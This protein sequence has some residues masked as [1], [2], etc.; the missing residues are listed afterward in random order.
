MYSITT[1]TPPVSEPV[2]VATLKAS[3][4]LNTS[5]EDS[6]LAGY[7]TTARMQFEH[8][9]QRA[10]FTQTLRQYVQAIAHTG[11]AWDVCDPFGI[12]NLYPRQS[13]YPTL[14]I[15]RGDVQSVSSVHYYDAAGS[16]QTSSTHT[17]DLI[18]N[19]A[20]VY[21]ASG[22]PSIT[23]AQPHVAYCD[24]V[25]GWTSVPADVCTAIQLMASHYYEQRSA[26]VTDNLKE[27]PHGF[28]SICSKYTLGLS[29]SWGQ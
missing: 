11:A 18:G 21:W 27:L 19:P 3:L 24:F 9:T 25:A 28:A 5:D 14:Y 7:I 26:Y 2:S 12:G 13:P 23:T 1:I 15:M 20:R 6:L 17:T 8:L 29:G 10:V 4:R 22:L 16:L